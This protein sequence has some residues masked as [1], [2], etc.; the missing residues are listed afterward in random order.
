MILVK[1]LTIAL[2]DETYRR[3][4]VRAAEAG[5]SVSAMVK[6]FLT[7]SETATRVQDMPIS[8]IHAPNASPAVPKMGPEGQ[9]YF[10]NGKWTFT[11]DGKPRQPG[12]LRGKI[13]MADEFDEWPQDILDSFDAWDYGEK[14]KAT[15]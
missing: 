5:T 12:G 10:V 3:A 7:E 6:R 1:N 4:R 9:P 14:P 11:K 15:G 8:F 13:G 2:D